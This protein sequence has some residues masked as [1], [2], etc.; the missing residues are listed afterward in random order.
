MIASPM[1][2]RA[3]RSRATLGAGL[4][5]ATL[6]ASG[7]ATTAPG[8]V[9]GVAGVG[10]DP[11]PVNPADPWEA[12]NRKVYAFNDAVDRAV[13]RPVAETYAQVVPSPARQAVGNFF[14]NFGDMW[15]IVNNLLQGKVEG[16]F[17]SLVRV[18]T[19]T[20]FGLGGLID[21]AGESGLERR[22][23]DL[24]QTLGTWGVGG[25]PYVVLPLFGPSTLRDTITFVPD[26]Y[27][28]PN[29]LV[30]RT[31]VQAALTTTNVVNTRAEILP[32]TRMLNTIAL[33]PYVFVRDAYLQRRL[34]QVY[35]GNPPEPADEPP[36]AARPLAPAEPAAS[37][38]GQP[39]PTPAR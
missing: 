25:G 11:R 20:V 37:A 31:A 10:L 1:P 32:A 16:A 27:V 8:G 5:A 7:C 33:D 14:G 4:L 39:N 12:W 23:E 13:L 9:A 17:V 26:R 38:P 3:D 6:L 24:G 2:A 28:S 36:P 15:S 29:L 35:D 21:I 19:N 30:E 34:N 18:G 22:S